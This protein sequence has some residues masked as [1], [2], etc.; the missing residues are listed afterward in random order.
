VGLEIGDIAKRKEAHC[1]TF[2]GRHDSLRGT[3]QKR[4]KC[5]TTSW[6]KLQ[7]KRENEAVGGG[8]WRMKGGQARIKETGSPP[9]EN[10]LARDGN[11]KR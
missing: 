5:R 6:A 11:G 4:V 10:L 8:D 9:K 2:E 7:D 1:G 3:F